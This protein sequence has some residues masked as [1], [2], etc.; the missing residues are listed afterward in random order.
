MRSARA[1]IVLA[2]LALVLVPLAAMLT[3]WSYEQW[4]IGDTRDELADVAGEAQRGGAEPAGLEA[5]ARGHDVIIRVVQPDG[6]L[7]LTA[8]DPES[9]AW[10]RGAVEVVGD[11][12][13]VLRGPR[14]SWL[15]ADGERGPLD[16]RSEVSAALRGQSDFAV[17]TSSSGETVELSWAAPLR[18]GRV[19]V[20]SKASHRFV[21]RLL[22]LQRE[23]V[24]ITLYQAFAALVFAVA[25]GRWLVGPLER[26]ARAAAKYPVESLAIPDVLDRR[27][28]VGQL[29]RALSQ[30]TTTLEARRKEAVDVAA[31]LAHE[32]KNPL[33]TIA[34]AAEHLGS[35]RELTPEKRQMLATA[36]ASAAQRLLVTTEAL[37]ALAR[38]EASL[39]QA[40]HERV[41]YGPLLERIVAE[42]R[43]DPRHDGVT[44]TLRTDGV[45]DVF[46]ISPAW[47]RLL[48]NLF[49]NAAVHARAGSGVPTVTVTATRSAHDVVTTVED[50]GPGVSDGN[51]DKIFRRFFTVRPAGQPTGT[52]LGLSI[53]QAVAEAHGAR[54]EL[55]S[56]PGTGAVF[57]VTLPV[58]H[59]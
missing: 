49:D 56:P 21:R 2:A 6:A 16:E 4:L 24:R 1:A 26:L 13:S 39:P 40:P 12:L 52:G 23:M 41:P 33:A 10:V 19:V 35:T 44:F 25:L 29:S 57:Q 7:A 55:V 14:E 36:S 42:Y 47:E 46:I 54:V 53:V 30:L 22:S 51:R 15:T 8:G 32:F 18:D 20:V 28:E 31:E 58:L 5:L 3:A 27:D 11:A 48:H 59:P 9:G 17:Y 45:G 38:L 37:L 43:A 50:S 34:A